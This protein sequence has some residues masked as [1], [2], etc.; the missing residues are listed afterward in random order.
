MPV[1]FMPGS[2]EQGHFGE[3]VVLGDRHC[4]LLAI[5]SF[6]IHYLP[7]QARR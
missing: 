5:A 3:V 1:R 7:W 6:I 2:R 4:A